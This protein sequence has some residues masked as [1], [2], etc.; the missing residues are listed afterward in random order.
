MGAPHS[1]LEYHV[2]DDCIE[3]ENNQGS[4]RGNSRT[5]EVLEQFKKWFEGIDGGRR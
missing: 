3:T 1:S 5:D 4:S 2:E